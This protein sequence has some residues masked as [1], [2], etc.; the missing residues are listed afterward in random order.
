LD[1]ATRLDADD[2]TWLE[3]IHQQWVA[4]LDAIRD[5]VLVL[6][7]EN[8]V[9][10]VNKAF[11]DL[12]KASYDQVLGEHISSLCPWLVTGGGDVT[13]AIARAADNRLYR[14]RNTSVGPNLVGKVVILEDVTEEFALE[15]VERTYR[16]GSYQAFLETLESLLRA[17]GAQD[18]YTVMH[19]QRVADLSKKIAMRLGVSDSEAQA[20]YH[21]ARVHDLGKITVP[22]SILHKPGKLVQAE[23]NLIRLHPEAGIAV[24]KELPFPWPVHEVILQHHERLDGKGYPGG[25]RG[26]EISLA[27]RVVM[28]ADVVEAMA[29]HRP[30]RPALGI[31]PALSEINAGKGIRYDRTVVEACVDV[32]GDPAAVLEITS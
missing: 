8:R 20:I 10:R 19:C 31:A 15:E 32:L 7:A 29:T 22:S 3:S 16:E 4:T 1:L 5:A 12:C 11:A 28:V 24:V 18:P 26:E 27:V 17:L 13:C 25:L 9:V 6:D 30:Y 14:V 2:L 23:M 21:A